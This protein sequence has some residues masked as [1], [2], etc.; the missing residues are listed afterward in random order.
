MTQIQNCI[1][2]HNTIIQLD[3]KLFIFNPD[4]QKILS[5]NIAVVR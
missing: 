5:K 3:G 4:F 1:S 2:N